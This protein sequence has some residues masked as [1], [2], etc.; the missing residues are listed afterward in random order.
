MF[1]L[2]FSP[3]CESVPLGM[4][5]GTIPDSSITASTY[6][7]HKHWDREPHYARLG[8]DK[9]WGSIGNDSEP[10]IQV[11]L[12]S[13]HIVTGLQI[14]GDYHDETYQYW[15]KQIKVKMGMSEEDLTF[16]EDDQEMPEVNDNNTTNY[17][18]ITHAP[19]YPPIP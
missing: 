10:W 11:D 5:N 19:P 9:F 18:L 16:I 14:E 17:S 6:Q 7:T 15:V 1:V 8:Q 4:A 3:K 2:E 13:I 12:G